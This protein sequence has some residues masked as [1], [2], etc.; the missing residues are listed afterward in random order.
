MLRSQRLFLFSFGC[1]TY[2]YLRCTKCLS[3]YD[4]TTFSGK[5]AKLNAS[6]ALC[7]ASLLL[8]TGV[9]NRDCEGSSYR[10]LVAKTVYAW[11][12][13]ACLLI[14][15]GML[16]TAPISVGNNPADQ[17]FRRQAF[18]CGVTLINTLVPY[19]VVDWAKRNEEKINED[20]NRKLNSD[21]YF[22]LQILT[23][24][25]GL[26]LAFLF[27]LQGLIM[28][29]ISGDNPREL[30]KALQLVSSATSWDAETRIYNAAISKVDC[31]N[32]TRYRASAV[33]ATT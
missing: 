16:H 33:E 30:P 26:L 28:L 12:V 23:L 32:K 21:S 2:S 4:S 6:L 18:A 25:V 22:M 10:C 29:F 9:I 11:A 15:V 17:S 24:V 19:F 8:Q 1:L 7:S 20:I 13:I 31:G 3:S 5:S 27:L 14:A